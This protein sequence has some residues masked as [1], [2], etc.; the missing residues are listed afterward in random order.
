MLLAWDTLTLMPHL[1]WIL[2]KA[3]ACKQ[4]ANTEGNIKFGSEGDLQAHD[5]VAFYWSHG[6]DDWDQNGFSHEEQGRG[7][8][9]DFNCCS[10]Q[11]PD[12][13]DMFSSS[14]KHSD[15]FSQTQLARID[16]EHTSST[17]VH[18]CPFHA[19]N[20]SVLRPFSEDH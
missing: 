11:L 2:V 4:S 12:L 18:H 3:G 6:N 9:S 1:R 10:Q 16:D 15:N 20:Q 19:R 13:H 14:T 17:A 8:A 7:S 5:Y